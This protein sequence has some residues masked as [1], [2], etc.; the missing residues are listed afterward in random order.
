[1]KNLTLIVLM[2]LTAFLLGGLIADEQAKV[3]LLRQ[4]D[5]AMRQAKESLDQT[6]KLVA[7]LNR[8]TNAFCLLRAQAAS[9]G[10]SNLQ[11]QVLG[12]RGEDLFFGGAD[13]NG[14][15]HLFRILTTPPP[16]QEPDQEPV[17]GSRL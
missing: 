8:A 3:R 11:M 15:V 2:F 9:V 1:M 7:I 13:S 4:R 12:Q 17:R 14:H 6:D 5:Q 10:I 16:D